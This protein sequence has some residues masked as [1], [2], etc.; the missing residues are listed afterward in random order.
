MWYLDLNAIHVKSDQNMETKESA[1]ALLTDK[2]FQNVTA[3]VG[4]CPQLCVHLGSAAL[5]PLFNRD[6]KKNPLKFLEI[7]EPD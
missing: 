7:T 3:L 5:V 4:T 2:W 1:V 6:S